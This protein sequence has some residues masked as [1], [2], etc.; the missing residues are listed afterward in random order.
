M[1]PAS[2]WVRVKPR[3]ATPAMWSYISASCRAGAV[4]VTDDCVN[5]AA[6]VPNASMSAYTTA[7]SGALRA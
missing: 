4:P 6:Y 1:P 2:A 7:A 3:N 5:V